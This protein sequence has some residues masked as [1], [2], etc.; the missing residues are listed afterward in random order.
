[1][2]NLVIRQY[3]PRTLWA[4]LTAFEGECDR[5]A[6]NLFGKTGMVSY[7]TWTP[8]VDVRETEDAYLLE[9]DLP[10]VAKEDVDISIMDGIVTIRGKHEQDQERET[11]GWH[12]FERNHGSFRRS[13]RLPRTVD[14][15]RVNATLD[16]GVLKLT[17]PKAEQ[18]K[19][20]QIQVT[21]G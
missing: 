11:N 4:G 14:A 21:T 17:L 18:A 20:K 5:L 19:R 8:K 2:T 15:E 13:V 10:G 12:C 1:M 3:R 6:G 7:E 9:A 16:N